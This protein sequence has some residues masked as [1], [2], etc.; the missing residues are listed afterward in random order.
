MAIN[1]WRDVS[2]IWKHNKLR[3]N[4]KLFGDVISQ[5]NS[6]QNSNITKKW[7]S[8]YYIYN[9]YNKIANFNLFQNFYNKLINYKKERRE[10]ITKVVYNK[11]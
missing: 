3:L 1:S 4:Y 9:N 7:A 8:K 6:E 2:N 11:L 5:Y 10:K